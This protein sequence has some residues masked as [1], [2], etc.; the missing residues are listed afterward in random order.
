VIGIGVSDAVERVRDA[1]ARIDALDDPA[2]IISLVDEETALA[3]A[4][5]LAPAD[6]SALCGMPVL[7]KDNIAVAGLPTGAG[8]PAFGRAPASRSAAVV[9]Q[10]ERAGAVVIGTTNMDQFA[11][12]LVGTR[13][14][15]GTP[16]NPRAPAHIPGGSSSGS[17]VAVARG[18]VPVALGTDTAGSGRVP[19]ACTNTVGLK[20]SRGRIDTTGVVPAI[21]GLDCVSIQA[22]TVTDAWNAFIAVAFDVPWAKA[23]GRAARIGRVP[24]A[25]VNAECD[26]EVRDAYER[27]CATAGAAVDVD[28][29]PFFAAGSLLYGPWVAA[30]VAAFGAFLDEHPA[31]VDPVV[32][33]VVAGGHAVTGAQVFA[34]QAAL[35]SYQLLAAATFERVDVLLVPT[36]RT[37]PT[38]AAVA[39]DPIGVNARLSRFTDFVNLLDCCAVA[40]P[41]APRAD[42]LP[43]GVSVIAPGGDDALAAEVAARVYGEPW[44]RAPGNAGGPARLAVV[45]AHLEGLPL[46]HQL[47]ELGAV[48]LETTR[49]ASRYRLYALAGTIPP[50]PGLAP[51]GLGAAIECEVYAIGEAE[52]G[53]F[54]AGVS[55]PLAIGPVELADGSVV[56]GFVAAAGALDGATDI[57]RFGGW[58]AYLADGME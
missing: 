9:E 36:I 27:T 16:R 55:S 35:A 43:F 7:V 3:R 54:V 53:R 26:P 13:S 21:P 17:A 11:T 52:L 32:A 1:Y 38:L 34:A 33:A 45:G 15:Y 4:R 10:L 40:V 56:P 2:V 39:E 14:P 24:A 31:D 48:R 51:D 19:A 20:P 41:G 42:G 57:T 37:L 58:R 6:G 47:T 22:R 28:M 12:G 49:T 50:K 18:I 44:T 30:R 46:H 29:D 8:C 25:V 23:D 5:A